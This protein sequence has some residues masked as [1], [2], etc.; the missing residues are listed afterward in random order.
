[1]IITCKRFGYLLVLPLIF[2]ISLT[3]TVSAQTLQS[4]VTTDSLTIGETFEYS[5]TLQ[6]DKEY[7]NIQFPDTNSFPATLDLIDRQ[8]FKVSEFSD[9]LLFTL[10]YFGNEDLQISPLAVTLFTETDSTTLFT[11]P[12]V[13]YFKTVVAEGD[14]TL[15][16]IKPNFTFAR[17]W[18]PWVLALIALAG[19]LIWWFY[20][21][22][23]PQEEEDSLVKEIKPFHNP[24]AEMEK[25]LIALKK[26][27]DLAE[28]KDFKGFYSKMSDT[29]RLYF[30]DLYQIPALESTSTELLRYLEAYGVDDILTDKT[31]AVLRKSDL[32]KFAKFTPTLDDAWNTYDIAIEF[33]ERAKMAD[34][35]RITRLKA[36][37][38]EQ[39]ISTSTG[40][41]KPIKED[42]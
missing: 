18:W 29:I 34:A 42:S 7:E 35:S 30:E 33:L 31:R 5:L 13:L 25:T 3:A 36:K 38:N 23:E 28:T 20:F 12:V 10:Q 6:L 41:D 16:P 8:L 4:R 11:E 14:T 17:S 22:K 26:D 9:S 24:L 15:K 39:F 32:V 37:Y 21:R 40:Q 27:N 1:M 2:A 19:G